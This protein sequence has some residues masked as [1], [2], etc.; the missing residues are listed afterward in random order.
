MKNLAGRT[1]GSLSPLEKE[2]ML[3]NAFPVDA[4]TGETPVETMECIVDFCNSDLSIIGIYDTENGIIID[5]QA[6]VY[7]P[8]E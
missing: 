8:C 3:D 6:R 5:N 1:W 7:N 2:K 4:R